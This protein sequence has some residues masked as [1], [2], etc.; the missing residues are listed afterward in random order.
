MLLI[1]VNRSPYTRCVA[2]L[3]DMAK[4]NEM[5]AVW[6]ACVART[7]RSV[8]GPASRYGSNIDFSNAASR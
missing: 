8:A 5:N 4:F 7:R 3:T 2:I 1:G 6:D